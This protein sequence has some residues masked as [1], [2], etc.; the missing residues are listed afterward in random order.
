[1]GTIRNC[2]ILKVEQVFATTH[3]SCEYYIII[4]QSNNYD[5]PRFAAVQTWVYLLDGFSFN[6]IRNSFLDL[7]QY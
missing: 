3:R 4:L 7:T 5:F 6:A 1:M 2:F